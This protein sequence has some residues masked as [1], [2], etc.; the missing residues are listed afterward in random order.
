MSK[1]WTKASVVTAVDST[2]VDGPGKETI[3]DRNSH[4][5]RTSGNP[6]QNLENP[7][8]PSSNLAAQTRNPLQ[9][10]FQNYAIANPS[11]YVRS[12]K[13]FPGTAV[14]C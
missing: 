8:N 12:A 10:V 11:K 7:D 1:I 2:I 14:Q 6:L 13:I 9:P 4:I 5:L 3:R